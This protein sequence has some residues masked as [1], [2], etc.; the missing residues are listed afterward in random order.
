MNVTHKPSCFTR[1][2]VASLLKCSLR[3]IDKML[4]S[5][6]L[7]HSKV[8]GKLIRIPSSELDRLLAPEVAAAN[9]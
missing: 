7:K 4:A 2:E 6:E 8:G 3:T 5:G 1:P 9:K